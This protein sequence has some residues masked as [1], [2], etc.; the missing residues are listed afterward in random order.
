MLAANKQAVQ[1]CHHEAFSLL[2][3]IQKQA[4]QQCR[5]EALSLESCQRA[6]VSS[7]R[8]VRGRLLVWQEPQFLRVLLSIAIGS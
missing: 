2:L 4:A 3:D 1:H 5:F 6:L 8:H 7:W